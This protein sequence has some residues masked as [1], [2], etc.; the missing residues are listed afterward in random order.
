MAFIKLL[1]HL[2]LVLA[3]LPHVLTGVTLFEGLLDRNT[4][5]A[6]KK[7]AVLAWLSTLAEK[8]GLPW[9]E[10]ALE[11]ISG[12]IDTVVSVLNFVGS[13]THKADDPPGLSNAPAAA[14]PVVVTRAVTQR[15][16]A[17]P[18]LAALLTKLEQ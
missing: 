2:P 4:S 18:E 6:D 7:A 16:S 10:A 15:A 9:G 17:D 5:G 3:W 12:L 11:V 8:S 14:D 1:K 13:F